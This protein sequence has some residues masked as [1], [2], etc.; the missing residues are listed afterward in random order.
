MDVRYLAVNSERRTATS[1][2]ASLTKSEFAPLQDMF[3]WHF[4][5]VLRIGVFVKEM[6]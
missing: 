6:G 5:Y 1:R 3:V 2:R 4:V